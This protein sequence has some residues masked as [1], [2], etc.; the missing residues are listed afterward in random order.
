MGSLL[1]SKFVKF[2]YDGTVDDVATSAKK[3]KIYIYIYI[4]IYLFIYFPSLLSLGKYFLSFLSLSLSLS[5][6]SFF[7][8]FWVWV[9][10]SKD[11]PS[12]EHHQW[13]PIIG[14]ETSH[15]LHLKQQRTWPRSHIAF[16]SKFGLGSW[17]GC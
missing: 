2:F 6:R 14:E 7:F 8:F 11:R 4:Y 17:L 5:L 10:G 16:G 13:Q 9:R 15:T 12:S 3:K 1:C